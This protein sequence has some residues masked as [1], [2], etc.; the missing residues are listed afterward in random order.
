MQISSK[1]TRIFAGFCTLLVL[2]AAAIAQPN[3]TDISISDQKAGSFLVYPYYNSNSQ[4][5][6]DTRLTLS[7]LSATQTVAVHVFF[8]DK[9]CNQADTYVCLTPNASIVMK[10]SEFDP[11]QL[12]WVMVVAVNANGFPYNPNSLI[13]NAF[14]IDG[15]YVGNY[16][17]EAF[18][19]M[20]DIRS[21]DGGTTVGF[22]IQAPSSLAV[23]LQSP[24]DATGQ[25]IVTVGLTGNITAGS[26][27]G[28]GQR[29]TGIIYNGNEKPF[30]SFGKLLPDGCR[31]EAIITSTVP[32][33]PLGLGNLI[34]A[35]QIGTMR[36]N[37]GTVDS[38]GVVIGGAVGLLMTP[39]SL[40]N[41]WSGIR[42]LHKTAEV[43]SRLTIPVFLPMCN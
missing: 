17:A 38:N 40:G 10:A 12:G 18:R 33:V 39:K 7:N 43:T 37:V 23:E 25:K 35:G 4:S 9:N 21:L 6:T 31:S 22:N 27:S 8:L 3:P 1:L 15:D 20:A 13:G 5:K 26:T 16:G 2:A 34:P 28:A 36:L 42:S 14:V 32:R 19:D 24:A 11:D 29:G 41:K 30:G